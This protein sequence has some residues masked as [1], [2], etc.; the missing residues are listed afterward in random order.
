MIRKITDNIE[1]LLSSGM[2]M[3][4]N[5]GEISNVI[6]EI[7]TDAGIYG[8]ESFA[9]LEE[10]IVPLTREQELEIEVQQLRDLVDQM[11]QDHT[12][13]R[14]A[15]TVLDSDSKKYMAEV[16]VDSRSHDK[17]MKLFELADKF[18]VSSN[19][20]SKTLKE[21]GV[22]NPRKVKQMPTAVVSRPEDPQDA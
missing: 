11:T 17:P 7:R 4:Q 9:L 6:L 13:L 20:A 1:I 18:N 16:W 15:R 3:D 21:I 5:D 22:Y 10:H 2:L 19:Y 8:P 12:P 14:K